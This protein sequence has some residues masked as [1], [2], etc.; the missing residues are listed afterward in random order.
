MVYNDRRAILLLT[1]N[2]VHEP[3]D[4]KK[5]YKPIYTIR[6]YIFM[7]I[8]SIYTTIAMARTAVLPQVGHILLVMYIL[9]WKNI[10][11]IFYVLFARCN[12]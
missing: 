6:E 3:E 12:I 11:V 10:D 7:F 1:D 8:L 4:T 2:F 9:Y 5:M